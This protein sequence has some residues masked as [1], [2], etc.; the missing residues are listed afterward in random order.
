MNN[1]KMEVPS[2]CA[3][4]IYLYLGAVSELRVRFLASKTGRSKTLNFL[5]NLATC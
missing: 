1:K 4:N 5:L 3:P 2:A